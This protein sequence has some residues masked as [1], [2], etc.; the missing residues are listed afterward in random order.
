MVLFFRNLQTQ[1][2]IFTYILCNARGRHPSLRNNSSPW[3]AITKEPRVILTIRDTTGQES[4]FELFYNFLQTSRIYSDDLKTIVKFDR[5]KSANLGG[6]YGSSSHVPVGGPARGQSAIAAPKLR[7][8][9]LKA[10]SL[11]SYMPVKWF[12]ESGSYNPVGFLHITEY[13]NIILQTRRDC[14]A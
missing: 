14:Q 3:F 10:D 8:E 2:V 7:T 9:G 6:S 13:S 11:A 5:P 4:K 12:F 1:K